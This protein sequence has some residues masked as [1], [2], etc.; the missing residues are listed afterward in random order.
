MIRRMIIV[1]AVVALVIGLWQL[2][3]YEQ[4]KG[5]I[6]INIVVLPED[7]KLTVDGNA[8]KAGNVYVAPGSHKLKATREDFE[9]VTQTVNT[10]EVKPGTIIYLLPKPNSEA[11]KN[12]LLQHPD[13]QRKRE[14]VGGLE[15]QQQQQELN[16]KF[17]IITK[18]PHENLH[19][20]I[21]YSISSGRLEF[22]I[23]LYAIINRPSQHDQYVQQLHQYKSEA[24]DYL[25]S[26]G[27][28]PQNYKISY[29]PSTE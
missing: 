23:T 6:K 15:A 13:V 14:A 22:T 7:S 5:L 4:H 2:V 18:L 9:D 27:I 29:I 19:Y 8:S 10:S 16:Q 11:A 24:L 25:T 26:N 20:K 3:A 12:W 28:N 21:D 1:A 17:P